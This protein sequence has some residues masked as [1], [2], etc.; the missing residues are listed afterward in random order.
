MRFEGFGGLDSQ[1]TE[2]AA[3]EGMTHADVPEDSCVAL[4]A[5]GTPHGSLHLGLRPR[6][7]YIALSALYG[8][9]GLGNFRAGFSDGRPVVARAKAQCGGSFDRLRT[10]FSATRFGRDDGFF[11]G[12]WGASWEIWLRAWRFWGVLACV[13]R[14]P[15]NSRA[16]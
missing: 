12:A 1:R 7:V 8:I 4:S 2:I 13:L 3:Q 14:R 10:G 9:V 11:W 16:R 5:L 6:L 15:Y